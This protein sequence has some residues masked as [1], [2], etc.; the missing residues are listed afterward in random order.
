VSWRIDCAEDR[1]VIRSKERGVYTKER[2]ILIKEQSHLEAEM[3]AYI[4]Q[5][6]GE[7]NEL[8]QEYWVMRNKAGKFW[9]LGKYRN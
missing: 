6:E 7:I 3:A 1:Y 9:R 4:A 8:L 5:N 2:E